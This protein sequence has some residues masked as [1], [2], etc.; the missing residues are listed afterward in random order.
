MSVID[1]IKARLDPVDLISDTV[2]LRRSGKNYTGF[3]PF[4]ENTRTPAFV[5]FPDTGTW[6]CFGQCNEGGDIFQFVMKK[7]G[8]DFS[9]TLQYLAER[10]GVELRPYTPQQAEQVEKNDQLRQ[11]LE[12]A[13]VFYRHQ[14]L[15]TPQG[16]AAQAYLKSR[17]LDDD[18]LETFGI[19]YAPKSWDDT[20]NYFFGKG[21][22]EA[23]LLAA[24]LVS[25]RESGG[26]YDRFRHRVT[27]PIRDERGRMAGFGARVLDADDL[28]KFL[29]SP[30]TE[31]FD[32]SQLLYG[33]D[34][35]RR[36]IRIM[37]QA[38][39]VE[40]YLDVVALHQHGFSNAVSPMGTALTEQHLR[41]LKRFSH[42]IVLALDPD[43]AGEKA[44]LRGLQIARQTMDREADLAFDARGLLHYEGRLQADIR[45]TTLPDG[46]D[47]DDIVARDPT[48][49]EKILA[50]ARPV[51]EHV[52]ETLAAGRDLDDPKVKNE[53]AAQVLPLIEDV[54]SSIERETYRQRLARLL[55]VDERSLVAR[56]PPRRQRVRPPRPEEA[57]LPRQAE[58]TV[59]LSRN[60]TGNLEVYCL[61]VLL[62]RPDLVYQLDR[63]LLSSG[64]GRLSIQDFQQ[65]ENQ[66]IFRLLVDSLAQDEVEPL[67]YVLNGLSETLMDT[68]ESLLVM[69]KELDPG[70]ERMM[71]E[72]RRTIVELRRR[73]LNQRIEQIRFLMEDEQ[74]KGDLRASA[75]GE[76]MLQYSRLLHLLDRAVTVQK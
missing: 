58:N 40:G 73:E 28:P 45:V 32:K 52:M 70:D 23:D 17:G 64:L 5:V 74:D 25:E 38:V 26:V 69:S 16:Q 7:E 62:R 4:H 67:H 34:Q 13:V 18:I 21:Y 76:T 56:T 61:G 22:S 42:R 55:R 43:A 8:W 11:L 3:C 9:E 19:G 30:Q 39:I 12:E 75:F 24:G 68:A 36:S 65:S 6:R 47:P 51:V 72:L 50:N 15:K 54:P 63:Y 60:A 71:E 46:M 41:L 48:E 20:C 57:Y 44:T 27:F 59:V 2:Q 29:N 33:L 31:L 49:W 53:I 14:L 1:E 35:A 37:E 66:A 10:A